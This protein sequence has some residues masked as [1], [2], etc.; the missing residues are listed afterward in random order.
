MGTWFYMAPEQLSGQK[1][2]QKVDIFALGVIFLELY[3]P[4]TAKERSQVSLLFHSN[5][6]WYKITKH[7]VLAVKYVNTLSNPNNDVRPSVRP[8]VCPGSDALPIY[9]PIS[10][11]IVSAIQ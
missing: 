8:S 4:L 6:R 7:T 10:A 9:G 5:S 1:Y 3:Y 2:D 11:C